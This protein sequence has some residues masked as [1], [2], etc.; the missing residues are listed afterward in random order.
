MI[1]H[2]ELYVSDLTASKRFWEWLFVKHL[3]YT[4]YQT[5]LQ[6]ISYRKD[7]QS[8]IVLVQ[9]SQDKITPS[10]NRTHVGLNHLAFSISDKQSLL[11]IKSEVHNL[12]YKELYENRYPYASGKKHYALYVEDPD[13]IKVEL[14][15]D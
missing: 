9:V 3:G 4:V 14:V 10:Y 11:Q 15:L 2:I 6:G 1:H 12:N 8:Y 7:A 5:W 13:R